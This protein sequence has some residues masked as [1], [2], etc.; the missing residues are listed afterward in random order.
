MAE[1]TGLCSRIYGEAG[2]YFYDRFFMSK[3]AN[4][5]DFKK[6]EEKL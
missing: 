5:T 1:L 3:D 6:S 2:I 4:I